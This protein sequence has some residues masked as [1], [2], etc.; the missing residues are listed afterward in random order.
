[1]AYPF[2]VVAE[3]KVRTLVRELALETLVAFWK[4]Q[5]ADQALAEPSSD[6][7]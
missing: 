4:M 3:A 5:I 7:R 6:M 1:L 2:Q